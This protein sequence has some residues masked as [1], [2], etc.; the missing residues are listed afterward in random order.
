MKASLS[1]AFLL[2]SFLTYIFFSASLSDT[3]SRNLF[4][5]MLRMSQH[6][7]LQFLSICLEFRVK[8]RNNLVCHFQLKIFLSYILLTHFV[9]YAQLYFSVQLNVLLKCFHCAQCLFREFFSSVLPIKLSSS[10]QKH[11][12]KE[13]SKFYYPNPELT[14]PAPGWPCFCTLLLFIVAL[15]LV[16]PVLFK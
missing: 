13:Y 4:H 3:L 6:I 12:A 16:A 2:L 1:S 10:L 8:G 5:L 9:A 14:V 11:I 15:F 7:F